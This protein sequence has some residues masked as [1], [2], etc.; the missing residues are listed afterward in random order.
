MV[1]FV[2]GQAGNSSGILVIK[3]FSL[4]P[5]SNG[6]FYPWNVGNASGVL[7]IKAISLF[8]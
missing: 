5:V 6:P 2:L 3:T 8:L 7:V 1:P 4:V